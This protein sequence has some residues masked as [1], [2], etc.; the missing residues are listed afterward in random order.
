[1]VSGG[2]PGRP[3]P[4]SR[5]LDDDLRFERTTRVVNVILWPMLAV[6]FATQ[7]KFSAAQS[8]TFALLFGAM[9]WMPWMLLTPVIVRGVKRW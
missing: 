3:D 8:W 2:D 9:L 7:F 1:M 5:A 4:R 6:L